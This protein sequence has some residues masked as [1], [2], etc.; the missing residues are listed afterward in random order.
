MVS[1]FT[2]NTTDGWLISVMKWRS[3]WSKV[4]TEL[5][6]FMIY[7]SAFIWVKISICE[8]TSCLS[9][10][11]VMNEPRVNCSQAN[12]IMRE[13]LM[14]SAAQLITVSQLSDEKMRSPVLILSLSNCCPA[15]ETILRLTSGQGSLTSDLLILF[16]VTMSP[17]SSVR[18]SINGR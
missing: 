5:E 14:V 18:A 12:V 6:T 11:V 1:C 17:C 10:G 15:T 9:L 4:L 2:H 13:S 3:V 8:L 7:F 16:I